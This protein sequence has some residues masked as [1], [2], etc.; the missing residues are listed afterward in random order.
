MV[1]PPR[2]VARR[3]AVVALVHPGG[4]VYE[5]PEDIGV[6]G[7]PVRISDHSHYGMMPAVAHISALGWSE[8]SVRM[9]DAR[10]ESSVPLGDIGVDWARVFFGDADALNAWQHED[11]VDGLADIAFWG[12][13]ADEAAATF[14]AP[15]LGEHGEDD[16]RGWTGLAVAEAMER[17]DALMSW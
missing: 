10:A 1:F 7:V 9:S 2:R 15:E 3:H 4:T 8:I 17:A 6:P 16:V 11:P 13:A 14:A 5:L 12:A